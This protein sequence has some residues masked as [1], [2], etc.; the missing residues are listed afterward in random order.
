MSDWKVDVSGPTAVTGP[1]GIASLRAK[2]RSIVAALALHHPTPATAASLAPLIWGDEL[3]NTAIKSVHNHVSRIRTSTPDLIDTAEQGYRFHDGI[4]I[5]CS[6][7]PLSY[8]DLADQPA[9]TVARARDRVLALRRGEDELRDRVRSGADDDLLADVENLLDAAPQRL[10]RWWWVALVNAR[11]GRRRRALDALRE[12]RRGPVYLDDPSTKALDL[13]ERAIADDDVFLDS[14][15][16]ADPR[17]LGAEPTA[18]PDPSST[19]APVGIIDPTGVIGEVIHAID[20]GTS[21]SLSLVAPAGGGKSSALAL[22]TQRLAPLGWNCFVTT[23]SPIEIDPL[24]PL[25]DLDTQRRERN[26]TTA[27]RRHDGE[28]GGD[29]AAAVLASVTA[30]GNRRVLLVV[31]DVH[32]ATPETVVQLRRLAQVVEDTSVRIS[33]L[34]ATR[35]EGRLTDAP[36]SIDVGHVVELPRWERPAIDAYLHSFVPP[37]PWSNGAAQWIDGRADGNALFVRELTIDVLRRLPDDPAVTPFVEPDVAS[38]VAGRSVLRVDSLP[39]LLRD[40]L[41]SAAVLGDEFRRSHLLELADNASPMMALGQ[42]HGLIEAVDADRWKG[43]R[44]RFVHQRFRQ[45]FL[46]LISPD[47]QVSIAQRV[48]TMIGA[49]TGALS[50]GALSADDDERLAEIARF[51]RTASSRDPERAIDATMTQ[52][53]SAF[54]GLRSE[55]ALSLARLAV[56]LVEDLEGRS[57]RWAEM[58]VLAGTAAVDAGD[59]EAPELLAAGGLRAME[60]A[61]H[62]TVARAATRLCNLNQ[63]T[64]VGRIEAT[65]ATLFAHAYEHVVEPTQRALVCRAGATAAS[66]ADDPTTSRRLYLE[67]EDLS[68]SCGDP[69]VRAEVLATAYTPLSRPDDVEE[70]RRI[71]SELH[72]LGGELGRDDLV[73]GAHRLDF[74]NAMSAGDTD[75]RIPM[76]AIEELARRLGQRSRNWTLFNFRATVSLLDGDVIEA[77]RHATMLLGTDVTASRQLIASSYGGH[78][79]GIRLLED[80]MAELD[81]LVIDLIERQPELM[82]WKAARVVTGALEHPDEAR[83]AFDEVFT[84]GTHRIPESFTMLGGLVLVGEGVV[85]LG[86]IDRVHTMIGH[87]EP[88]AGRWGWFN[89][90]SIGPVDLTLARLYATTG[91]L[92]RAREA[93]IRGLRS[94]ASVGAPAYAGQLAG[95]LAATR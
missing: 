31:D 42:A 41:I 1:G 81:P 13:F 82:I 24:A 94:T 25:I 74:A 63:T 7:G 28:A 69:A 5:T 15:A 19:V 88:F 29:F 36:P 61:E 23:C 21:P 67:S 8:L 92:D 93:A 6:G 66:M 76:A 91:D 47:E 65:T 83:S 38:L 30:P 44:W 20:A 57:A 87:L 55:E 50:A 40:T 72:R 80:R 75:P 33:I 54:R 49:S 84:N 4:E 26:A 51:A 16:A 43:E 79:F 71:A 48:T 18:G 77:E 64:G 60:L 27:L 58:T 73:Y 53:E 95:I 3:P 85:R 89:V 59:P 9:V 14:P 56:R 37:G 90:G 46:D 70:R 34:L 22:I 2:E 12:C 78:M 62:D 11:L 35:P 17:S 10:V 39:P 45:S 68:R 52:A 86:D 32:H